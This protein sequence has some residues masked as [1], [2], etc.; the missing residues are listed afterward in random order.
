MSKEESEDTGYLRRE[1]SSS[2]GCSHSKLSEFFGSLEE[3]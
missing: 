2:A 3:S 1:V